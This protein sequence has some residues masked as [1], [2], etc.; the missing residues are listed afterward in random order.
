MTQFV[1]VAVNL[2]VA[3][4]LFHYHLPEQLA[5]R[6]LPGCLVVVPLGK[7][8]VQGVVWRL[9]DHPAVAETRPVAELLDPQPVLT[10]EQIALAEWMARETLAPLAVCFDLM[11]PPGLSQQV[12]VLYRLNAAALPERGLSS[13]Q[14]RLAGLLRERGPLRGRQID[15]FMGRVNWRPAANQMKRLGWLAANAVLPPPSV[16]PKQV[17]QVR[18]SIPPEEIDARLEAIPRQSE[19]VRERRRALLG[20]LAD[21]AEPV[22][23]AWVFAGAGGGN[24]ADLQRLAEAGL[25][26]FNEGEV[27]RDPLERMEFTLSDAPELTQAQGEVWQTVA[28][29]ISRAAQGESIQPHLLHG[30]TSSGK[31]EIYLQAVGE[32]LRLG[33]Q[34]LVLVPEI[35]LTPQTVRRFA[36]RF[37]GQVGLIHSRLSIGERYDTWRRARSGELPVIVGPRSALFTP[38]PDLGLIVVDE[39]HDESYYQ[40]DF[41]PAYSAV[42]AALALGRISRALVLLGSATPDV[43]LVQRARMAKWPLL[44]LPARILAHRQAVAQQFRSLGRPAPDLAA[45]GESA[46][47][48]LPPVQVVDMRQELKAGNR[49]IFSRALQR[50]LEQVLQRGEQ[51]ILFLNRRG[52]ATYVFCRE[53]GAALKCPRCDL[54]LTFHANAD[55]LI[56]HT[57]NYRRKMPAKCPACGSAS[58]RQV[59][60]G[61]E[62]VETEVQARFPGARTLRW[63]WET[64]REKDAHDLILSHFAAQRADV[65]IGTQMVAKGLDLPLVTLVGVILADIGLQLPDYRAGERGFQL[66]TQVAGRAGRSPLGGRVVL[67]TY[68]PEHYAIQAASRHDYQGF[69]RQELDYRRKLGYP[70]FARLARLELRDTDERLAEQEARR[71]G[72]LV[73]GWLEA[74]GHRGTEMIGPAPC[75]FSRQ[76]GQYRWQIIL[77][78]PDPAAVLRGQALGDWRVQV[79]PVSLL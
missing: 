33:R 57:C 17:R 41:P 13:L 58:I 34:A 32:T 35:S 71:M 27:W 8:E 2:P 51:A 25:V 73:R 24:A 70:P 36:A 5:G 20:F 60:L 69:L 42:E 45:E 15:S 79:D 76:G 65:L 62:R 56:C 55:A 47:I 61:T 29:S 67:Q 10:S 3:V 4:D 11:L 38:L 74:G 50:E 78:G 7:K 48:E 30:I 22:E 31:T 75:F 1:E 46:L 39:C 66:L 44:S 16:R 19:K 77:R 28:A 59:G 49:T 72:D 23:P 6:V 63:D 18:L 64:T 53:C 40:D 9:I 68:L 52:S 43:S 26:A 14:A 37:P 21:Q 54:P 12:D